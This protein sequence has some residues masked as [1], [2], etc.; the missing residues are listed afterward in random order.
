MQE[1]EME[2]PT[3]KEEDEEENIS[4]EQMQEREME[5]SMMKEEGEKMLLL[6]QTKLTYLESASI[7]N[8]CQLCIILLCASVAALGLLCGNGFIPGSSNGSLGSKTY[9][10]M[11]SILYCRH[12]SLHDCSCII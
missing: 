8:E 2:E 7:A 10:K 6:Q 3:L 4:L 12:V 1:H 9:M 5:E 11:N